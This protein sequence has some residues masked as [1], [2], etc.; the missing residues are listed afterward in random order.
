MVYRKY[1]LWEYQPNISGPN[2]YSTGFGITLWMI[3]HN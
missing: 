3:D 2:P 1:E